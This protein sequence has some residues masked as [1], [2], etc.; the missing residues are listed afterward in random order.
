MD[1]RLKKWLTKNHEQLPP[2]QKQA[3]LRT[4]KFNPD[5]AT[6]VIYDNL[7]DWGTVAAFEIGGS[8]IAIYDYQGESSELTEHFRQ[9]F[10]KEMEAVQEEPPLM[11]ID[12]VSECRPTGGPECAGCGG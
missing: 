7:M 8:S 9:H 4:L 6:K 12:K 3:F 2:E 1:A 10:A 5:L 11:C